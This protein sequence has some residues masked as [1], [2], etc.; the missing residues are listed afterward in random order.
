MS[1]VFLRVTQSDLLP[2]IIETIDFFFRLKDIFTY[3][4]S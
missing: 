4:I 1:A 3:K 2:M